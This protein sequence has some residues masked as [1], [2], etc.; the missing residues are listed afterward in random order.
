VKA[1]STHIYAAPPNSL[2]FFLI[3]SPKQHD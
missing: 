1:R 2:L 3:I